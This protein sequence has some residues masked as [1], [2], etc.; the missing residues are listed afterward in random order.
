MIKLENTLI[1]IQNL[2]KYFE[3]P[4]GSCKAVNGVNLK[5]KQGE[6]FGLVGESGCGKS[7][8]VRTILKLIEPTAGKIFLNGTDIT[9]YEKEQLREL[10][11]RMSL[12]F[13]DPHSSL[14]PRMT[15]FDILSRPFKIHNLTSSNEETMIEIVKLLKLMGMQPEHMIRFPHEL[16]GG[17]KQRIGVARALAVKPEIIFLDEPT[18]ALDVSVQTKILKLLE[19]TKKL[20]DLTYFYISHDINLIR[21]VSDRIGVMYLGKI[22]EIGEVD[23]IYNDP[24]HPYTRGLFASVPEPDPDKKIEGEPL[25]GEVPSPVNP[26][27]G[28]NFSPRCPFADDKCREVEPELQYLSDG[29]RV[30]CHKNNLEQY[31]LL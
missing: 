9:G 10:R 13:Q 15:V 31:D 5:I 16:S 24:K 25:T 18:S 28:C 22:V 6:T 4:T 14:N 21:V 20:R 30:A 23:A 1:E 2:K 26:P 29:R 3:T 27:K 12:V 7:T 8:L 17:Q 19:K 11:K